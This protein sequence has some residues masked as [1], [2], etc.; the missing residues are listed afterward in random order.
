MEGFA[1]VF[2]RKKEEE[3]GLNFFA[4]K[5]QGQINEKEVTSYKSTFTSYKLL[6]TKRFELYE[7]MRV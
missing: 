4:S 1:L 3:E 5:F 7:A 2:I 6:F